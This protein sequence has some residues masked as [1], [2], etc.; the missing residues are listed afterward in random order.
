VHHKKGRPL[1]LW[2]YYLFPEYSAAGGKFHCFPGFS[3]HTLGWFLKMYAHDGSRGA[4]IEGVSDQIDTYVTLKLLDDPSLDVDVL[5]EEF[6]TRYYGAAAGPMK[7]LYLC[8]EDTFR[9][10]ANYP[11]EIQT[12]RNKQFHQT[13]EIAWKYLGTEARMAELGAL[14][15]EATRMAASEIEKQRVALFREGVWDYMVEGRKEYLAKQQKQ[16]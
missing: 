14:M 2:L 8:I 1:Y 7:R 16:P 10:S 15:D 3:A 6:F 12:N 5:L 11:K 13:E 9:N 4:F